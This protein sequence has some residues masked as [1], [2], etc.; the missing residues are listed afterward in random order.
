MVQPYK[1]RNGLADYSLPGGVVVSQIIS[2]E[3]LEFWTP[4][5]SDLLRLFVNLVPE[6]SSIGFRAPLSEED[7]SAYWTSLSSD[8]SGTDPLVYLFV[9]KDSAKSNDNNTLATFQLGQNPKETHKHK[10]EVRPRWPRKDNDV[11][12]H[13]Q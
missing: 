10:I 6:T 12:R 1:S 5:L 7:A 8:I 11:T 4:S 3:A 2:T 9:V 13:G